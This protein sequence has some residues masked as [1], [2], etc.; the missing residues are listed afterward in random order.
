[1]KAN[2]AIKDER[3]LRRIVALLFALAVLAERVAVRS[4]PVRFLVLCLLRRAESAAGA[5][6]FE[7]AGMP[8]AAIEGFAAVGNDPADA[9]RLA[10]R[11]H[12]LAAALGALL[13]D[14]CRLDR[15]PARRGFAFG[16]VASGSGRSLGGWQPKL[17]DTS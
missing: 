6:V 16:D 11:F 8:P 15:R 13:P 1:M 10:A 17:I 9:L 14:A 7:A 12:A 5:F 3:T 4:W 2:M